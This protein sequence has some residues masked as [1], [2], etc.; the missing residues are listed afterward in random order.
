MPKGKKCPKEKQVKCDGVGEDKA[1][2]HK[3]TKE[4]PASLAIGI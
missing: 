1:I 3:T 2:L 4:G